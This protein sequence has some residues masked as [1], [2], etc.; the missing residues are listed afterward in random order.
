MTFGEGGGVY[1]VIDVWA[2]SPECW[3]ALAEGLGRVT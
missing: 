2:F 3:T 1:G